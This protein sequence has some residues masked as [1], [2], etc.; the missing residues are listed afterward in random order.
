[1]GRIRIAIAGVGNCASALVQGIEYYR[2]APEAPGGDFIAGLMNREVGGYRPGDIEVV[3]AFDIDRRKVGIPLNEAIFSPP[4]CTTRFAGPMP[5]P[6]PIVR[7]GPV[8]DGV[9]PHMSEYPEDRTF[10]PSPD[11]PCDV[12]AVLRES[13]AEI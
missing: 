11:T 8:L 7:M 5:A 4:N 3:A 9:A 10:L 2:D 1:M 12:E 13:G 6:S